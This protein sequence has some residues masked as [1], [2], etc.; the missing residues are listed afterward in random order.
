MIGASAAPIILAVLQNGDNY[1][2][3]IILKVKEL[4]NNEINWK[5]ASIYPVLKKLESRGLIRSY[6][7]KADNDRHRKYYTILP[8]GKKQF[9]RN[10]HEWEMIYSLFGKL[11]N[12]SK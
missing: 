8:E 9:E 10:M 4:T 5:G 2:Y 11:W 7:K 1:G 12:L 6:W 3:D